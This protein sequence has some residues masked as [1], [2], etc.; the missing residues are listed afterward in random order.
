MKVQGKAREKPGCFSAGFCFFVGLCGDFTFCGVRGDLNVVFHEN[1]PHFSP[2]K[3]NGERVPVAMFVLCTIC[4]GRV[5]FCNQHVV[6]YLLLKSE[7]T[8]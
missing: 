2:R 4:C 1:F 7:A 8:V 5:C 6:L 3:K